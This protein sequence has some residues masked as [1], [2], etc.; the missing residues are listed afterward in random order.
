MHQNTHDINRLIEVAFP[1]L[2]LTTEQPKVVLMQSL[3]GGYG[4]I[5]RIWIRERSLVLK[6]VLAPE[7]SS[8]SHH[9]K[10]QSYVNEHHF[11]KF[12]KDLDCSVA[13]CYFAQLEPM[14]LLLEDLSS[15]YNHATGMYHHNEGSN[16][17]YEQTVMSLTWLATF[18]AHFWNDDAHHLAKK[19]GYWY[20]ETRLDEY[21]S[22]SDGELK[23]N[24]HRVNDLLDI[25]SV[26]SPDNHMFQTVIHGD[27]KAAN[28]LFSSRAAFVDF[29][30]C[31]KALGAVDVAYLLAT[32][33]NPEVLDFEQRSLLQV[34]YDGLKSQLNH[35][36]IR[37]D[38]KQSIVDKYS[39]SIFKK[40]FELAILDWVRFM[41]GWGMWG[42][43]QWATDQAQEALKELS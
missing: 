34:Y 30:Y 36:V 18:H 4:S 26:S 37:G 12:L 5:S 38:L 16:L 23:S 29:Q 31:G 17:G 19:G 42:N 25:N 9:R 21:E 14:T 10:V 24:A 40:H 43:V 39:F 2:D 32:S 15:H 28:I 3:W 13:E 8:V 41:D 22:M 1:G 6:K 33:V 11:Y 20:L 35:R 27:A 7:G